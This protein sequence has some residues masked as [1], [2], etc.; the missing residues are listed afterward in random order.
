M[1]KALIPFKPT[2]EQKKIF[3]YI[4]KR[5]DDLL[6]EAR[7]GAGKTSTIVAATSLLPKDADIIFLAFNK[8]I[9][10]ELKERLPENVRCYT[11]H[12][13]G[14]GAIHRKYPSIKFDEFKVDGIINKK[15][16]NWSLN[17]EILNANDRVE[18][19]NELKKFVNLC[20]LSLTSETKWMRILAEK[21][22][23]KY[24]SDKD[25]K[26]VKSILEVMMNDRTSYDFTDM[27]FLPAIDPKIWLFQ[28]DYVFLDECQDTN[29]AQQRMAEKM[30]KRDRKTKKVTGRL[31]S[32]GDP[33]QCQPQGTKILMYDGTEKNIEDIVVG[34][35]IVSYDR[36]HT[37]SFK[38]FYKNHRWGADSLKKLAPII[39]EIS[40]HKISEN[41]VVINSNGKTTKYTKN[42]RCFVRLRE[43]KKKVHGLYLME[44]N[45]YF[46]IGITP[47]WGYKE[48]SIT[49][50]SKQEYAEKFWLLNIYENKHD[51]YCDEQ[52][53]SLIYGIPQLRFKDNNTGLFTQEKIDDFY[54]RFDKETMF[55][56]AK[57]LLNLF[58]KVYDFPIWEKGEKNYTSKVH[59]F[60]I[61]AC[62][63]IGDYM[64]MI[65]FDENNIKMRSHGSIRSDKSLKPQYF[66]IDSL[67]YEYYDSYV[68]SLKVSKYECYVADGILTHNSIYFFAG[69]DQNSFEW[70]RKRKNTKVLPLSY[71]FRCAKAIVKKANEVVPD[72]K[73]LDSAEEGQ[74][75]KGSVIDEPESGD[76][77]LCRTVRPL[78][79]L[80]FK[81]LVD[82][83]KATIK[84]SDIGLSIIEMTKD[85][86]T[87]S[88][89]LAHWQNEL[90]EYRV[91]LRKRGVLN[92]E[93]D[94]GYLAMEDKVNTLSFMSRLSDDIA[95]LRKKI[96]TI[97]SDDLE[98]IVLSTVH[99]AKGLETDR[100]FIARPDKLPLGTS[101]PMQA[102]QEKNLVY[103]AITRA[104]KELIYDYEWSDEDE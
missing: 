26:R 42:H 81:Y 83:R 95:D 97:F 33:H 91:K 27:I 11:M 16:K 99:K 18:Y 25:I 5:K 40:K 86:K 87:Q 96:S 31:I 72:I 9:Q 103:V 94:S 66:D 47:L 10:E 84:G 70:F 48:N 37:A 89:M 77:V 63:I 46:R 14:R 2:E 102:T 92:P 98:G 41:L 68:Y 49:V 34:D 65:H 93:E 13:V 28:Q 32:I 57:K 38:G 80:F 59:L 23:L 104:K 7:A 6:I 69:A 19:L 71:T 35:R 22:E 61:R 29:R 3:K 62:N 64:Q 53:Y 45:G 24:Y 76:F 56:S 54:S 55:F 44:R 88:Q 60:E 17:K 85:H 12:G 82:G 30:L 101:N 36:K 51:A 73:A 58:N 100:V 15:A 20:R 39:K 75:R 4:D 78:I 67:T 8:H 52:Y 90:E 79:T 43:D 50:I 1:S 21:H 74:V